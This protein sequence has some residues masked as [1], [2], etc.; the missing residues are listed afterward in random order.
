MI[1][2]CD[3]EI[4]GSVRA[5]S[6]VRMSTTDV[7]RLAMGWRARLGLRGRDAGA[8][9][10]SE[11]TI[12]HHA[13][14]GRPVEVREID[15]QRHAWVLD[16]TTGNFVADSRYLALVDDGAGLMADARSKAESDALRNG[17]TSVTAGRSMLASCC[18]GIRVRPRIHRA[19]SP[20][21][22][23]SASTRSHVGT[24]RSHR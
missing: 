12:R 17:A 18:S 4:E 10:R 19:A 8:Q 1:R 20:S 6:L 21:A 24:R 5:R 7:G 2:A 16:M 3:L 11:G 13:V 22:C 14:D 9:R 15:G 23:R